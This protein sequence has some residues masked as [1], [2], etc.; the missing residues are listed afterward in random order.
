MS[1]VWV[2]GLALVYSWNVPNAALI[3]GY[4]L[5][6]VS[7][8]MS[9]LIVGWCNELTKEDDQVRAI[10]VGSLNLVAGLLS[11]PLNVYLFNTDLGPRFEKGNL[12][13][14][15]CGVVM[16]LYILVI[17][18][19]DRYQNRKREYMIQIYETE[20]TITDDVESNLTGTEERKT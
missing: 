2:V 8:G 16:V 17:L 10:T 1:L 13:C 14:L 5:Q 9:P 6:G 11:V 7:S 18:Q 3:V 20:T 15:I 19:F 4:T 12:A